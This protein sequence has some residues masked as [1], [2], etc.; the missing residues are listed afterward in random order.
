MTWTSDRPREEQNNGAYMAH[1]LA[2]ALEKMNA[3]QE[4]PSRVPWWIIRLGDWIEDH[5]AEIV[6]VSCVV[7]VVAL[8]Y[9]L[10]RWN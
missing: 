1:E 9:G 10:T 3:E 6:L 7:A 5:S 8:L 2:D 4:R